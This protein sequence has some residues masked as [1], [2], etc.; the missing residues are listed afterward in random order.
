M[1]LV[2]EHEQ[3]ASSVFRLLVKDSGNPK[4]GQFYMLGA[5]G[6]GMDPFLK[7]PLSVHDANGDE[8]EFV[9]QIVGRGTKMLSEIQTGEQPALEMFGPLGRG[10]E[11]ADENS[12]FIGGGVGVVPLYY[13]IKEFKRNFGKKA[14]AYLGFS[15]ETFLVD[16]FK[17]VCDEVIVN[18]GG[19]ITDYVDRE[20]VQYYTCG[21][22]P[23]MEAVAKLLPDGAKG[24][25]SL[26]KRM[27]CG[28][29]ACFACSVRVDGKMQRVCKDGPVF[30][31]KEVF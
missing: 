11:F 24:Y 18:V 19:Y 6:E 25:V 2:L 28:V 26:E 13:A 15:G 16:R 12:A 4:P 17:A 21:P 31:A 23:M 3:I 10:F 8:V 14:V 22:D 7:R 9:Y 27:G 30:L 20:F 1:A 29:G 5:S